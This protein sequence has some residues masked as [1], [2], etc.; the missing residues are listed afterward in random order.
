MSSQ[1]IKPSRWYYGLALLV[2]LV[3]VPCCV[4]LPFMYLNFTGLPDSLTQVVVPGKRDIT[5]SEP[6]TYIIYYESKTVVGNKV[7]ST[8]SSKERVI[9]ETRTLSGLECTLISKVTG[10]PVAI[11]PASR[12]TGYVVR[13][14][15][16]RRSGVS[17][18]EFTIAQPGTYEFSAAYAEGRAGP[19]VVLAIGRD[20]RWKQTGAVL[21]MMMLF[22]GS[23]AIAILIAAVT[24]IKRQKAKKQL[25]ARPS[26]R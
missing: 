4:L 24:F 26:L 23:V 6:G 17:V 15:R 1:T 13:G 19:E 7:Y 8:P 16:G 12:P 10:S 18:L 9:S 2:V 25:A 22:V 5:L 11:S 21:G 20:I 14:V 3:G